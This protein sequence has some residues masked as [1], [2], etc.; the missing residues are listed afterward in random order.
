MLLLMVVF[1]FCFVFMLFFFVCVILVVFIV[2]L[3]FGV[4]VQDEVFV[5]FEWVVV[6][7]ICGIKVIDKILGVVFVI[8]V[9]EIEIQIFVVEDF[10]V[11]LVVLVL[12]YVLLCQKMMSFG[13]FMCGCMVLLLFDGVLQS[14][15]LCNGVCEGYFVDLLLIKC[16]E[17]IFGVLVVQGLGVIGGIIN[18][19]LCM[20][21]EFG[22]C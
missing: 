5:L 13:E 8:M 19:I 18:F 11:V 16:I 17:V 15:L 3:F 21:C 22:M 2:M 7:V 9:Q 4:Y 14:N 20:L 1:V 10:S 12:F 6:I